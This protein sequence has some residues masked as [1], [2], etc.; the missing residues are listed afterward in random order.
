MR[1]SSSTRSSADSS[2]RV[3]RVVRPSVSLV[4]A[5]VVVRLRGDLR[6]VRHA[7]H[8]AA[9]AEGAQLPAD[10][11]G[12]G[13]ADAGVDLV[14]HHAARLAPAA[15]DTCTASDRRDELAAGGHLGERARR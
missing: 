3:V 14:E 10:D 4:D 7:Q 1:A 5:Q 9:G 8:L 13:A 12:D 6:Q 15:H 11:L 2:V